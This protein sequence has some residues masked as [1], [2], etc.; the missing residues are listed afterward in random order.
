[1]GFS[2]VYL[3]TYLDTFVI[4]KI[5]FFYL[6]SSS[7]ISTK[8]YS[9]QATFLALIREFEIVIIVVIIIMSTVLLVVLRNGV[10]K[11]VQIWNMAHTGLWRDGWLS[12]FA[13]VE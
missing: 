8:T 4:L 6:L 12:W 7:L 5:R 13:N 9:F 11:V 1:M 2:V 10:H 3:G